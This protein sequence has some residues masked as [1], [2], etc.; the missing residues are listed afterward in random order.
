MMEARISPFI[1]GTRM[2]Y[3]WDSTSLGWFKE[4]PRK[5][6]YHM[7]EGWTG[8]GESV[9]LQ[10]GILYHGALE[11]Y[12]IYRYSVGMDHNTALR[13]VVKKLLADTW[14][15]GKPWRAIRDLSPD[16]K[17][18]LKCREFLVRSVIWYLDKF[19]MEN[20][21]A[22]T[23][24]NVATGKPMVELHFQFKLDF[25]IDLAHQYQLCGHLDRIVEFQGE[26][27][28]MDRKSSTSTLGSYYFDQYDPDNQM[29]L[30]TIASQVA[31]HAPVKGVI[32]D[33]LQ[34]AVGFSR[35]VRS[36]VM[37]TQD[38]LEEWMKDLKFWLRQAERFAE[39]N[40]WPMNDKSCHKYGGCPF[41]E[42]CS[43]S[44]GIRDKFL[45]SNF[46]RR[47]WNPLIPR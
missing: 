40:Y 25:G 1:D 42:I 37:K 29:T 43:K 11:S 18:S 2:Q 15:D 35:F 10:F 8:R 17:T 7:L 6:Q 27:F 14:R 32:I 19:S 24:V 46:E 3:A 16:D 34:V 22:K 41:R 13:A 30:Y 28:V 5:Y 39:A 47:E 45:E 20:D 26:S 4:C 33:A 31:F 36:M 9:H 38:Q 44:P 21:P 23:R 12:D